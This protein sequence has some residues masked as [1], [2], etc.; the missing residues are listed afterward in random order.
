M[1]ST[2]ASRA[3]CTIEPTTD[4]RY[5]Q[6]YRFGKPL[7]STRLNA[8]LRGFGIRSGDVHVEDGGRKTRKGFKREQ[9]ENA[10]RRY[11][12]TPDGV[13]DANGNTVH[14]LNGAIDVA[15][16]GTIIGFSA[17]NAGVASKPVVVLPSKRPADVPRAL[18]PWVFAL[19]AFQHHQ[20]RQLLEEGHRVLAIPAVSSP[21]HAH[22]YCG[23]ALPR[24]RNLIG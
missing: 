9:F 18:P 1:T 13:A 24:H 17:G 16:T 22:D 5:D 3:A 19:Y 2:T 12:S 8:L 15:R 7:S 21:L 10:W 20:G 4:D 11:L 23:C 6:P 14:W